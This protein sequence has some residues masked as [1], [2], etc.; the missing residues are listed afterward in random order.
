MSSGD[1]SQDD[2]IETLENLFK[3]LAKKRALAKKQKNDKDKPK[4]QSKEETNMNEADL[5]T[6]KIGSGNENSNEEKKEV[7]LPEDRLTK[8]EVLKYFNPYLKNFDL[9]KFDLK[10]TIINDKF[11]SLHYSER[12]EKNSPS[13]HTLTFDMESGKG[14][15]SYAYLGEKKGSFFE[16]TDVL[17]RFNKEDLVNFYNGIEKKSIDSSAEKSA[18]TKVNLIDSMT[19]YAKILKLNEYHISSQSVTDKQAIM[20]L[21]HENKLGSVM[22]LSYNIEKESGKLTHLLSNKENNY[23]NEIT[24]RNEFTKADLENYGYGKTIEQIEMER[25][26]QREI[27]EDTSPEKAIEYDQS[28]LESQLGKSVTKQVLNNPELL[29]GAVAL[30]QLTTMRKLLSNSKDQIENLNNLLNKKDVNIEEITNVK[31]N[32]SKQMDGLQVKVA[33]LEKNQ[34]TTKTFDTLN[35]GY[36]KDQDE[37]FEKNMEYQPTR[38]VE[39]EHSM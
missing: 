39:V 19:A 27:T 22:Q 26:K 1:I 3:M 32:L 31:D 5:K 4:E 24:I 8:E 21:K 37:S 23:A 18:S 12:G 17:K 29:K 25:Q 36:K 16:F 13:K 34:E 15:F 28:V 2:L 33:D 10:N 9:K 6:Q 35:E 30:Y 7:L 20:F 11:V 38:T 14:E